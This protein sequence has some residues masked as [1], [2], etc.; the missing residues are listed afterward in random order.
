MPLKKSDNKKYDVTAWRFTL[1]VRNKDDRIT[2]ITL[3]HTRSEV[4]V[5]ATFPSKASKT[6][7]L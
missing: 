4:T 2:K 5:K 1:N 6:D 3:T 7:R